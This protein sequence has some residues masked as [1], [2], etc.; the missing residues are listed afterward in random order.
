MQ[1]VQ[2]TALLLVAAAWAF[3]L[4]HAA[5]YPGKM[6]LERDDY[7]ATQTIYYPGFTI[8]GAS[9]P[10]AILALAALLALTPTD[11]LSF[12]LT[13]FALIATVLTHA[14]FWLM[15]QPVNRIWTKSVELSGAGAKFFQTGGETGDTDWTRLR[16]RWERSHIYR[17]A[18]M[19][20][21]L[22]ALAIAVTIP[23]R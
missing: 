9:E 23:L 4:A 16:D 7:L 18:V 19:S 2:I 12:W 5:E 10:L 8:G 22:V 15:T 1:A 14:I 11:G 17:T 3:A 20:A 21:A 6:R 13:L